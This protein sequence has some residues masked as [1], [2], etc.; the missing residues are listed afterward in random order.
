MRIGPRLTGYVPGGGATADR[1]LRA[2][3][4]CSTLL[5]MSS[6]SPFTCIFW[7]VVVRFACRHVPN[8]PSDLHT[9]RPS[10]CP[11]F[12]PVLYVVL[13]RNALRL[14]FLPPWRTV[15]NPI[16]RESG[17]VATSWKVGCGHV[18]RNLPITARGVPLNILEWLW[19]TVLASVLNARQSFQRLEPSSQTMCAPSFR[20]GERDGG[21]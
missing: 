5:I 13:Q 18:L 15:W 2:V 20:H 19:A 7:C 21:A 17:Q 9:V 4:C 16:E 3:G 11:M 14:H 10:S 12:P 1:T 8:F 6:T